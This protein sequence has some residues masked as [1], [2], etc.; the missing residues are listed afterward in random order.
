MSTLG[1]GLLIST[2][3]K[4]QQQAM[5][6]TFFYTLPAVLLSGFSFPIAN[7][8]TPVQWITLLNPLRYYLVILRSVF[9][10]GVGVD[11]LWPQMLGLAILGP[12][13][14]GLSAMRFRK[15]LG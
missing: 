14:L 6:T 9:L 8:P 15:K 4:T 10:K 12:I 3:V 13:T 11:I 5:M 1:A 2:L 7:M